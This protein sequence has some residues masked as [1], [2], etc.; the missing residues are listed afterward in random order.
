MLPYKFYTILFHVYTHLALLLSIALNFMFV[1]WSEEIDN[2]FGLWVIG[3]HILK[4]ATHRCM[5]AVF[6]DPN[7]DDR[8]WK[9]SKAGEAYRNWNKKIIAEN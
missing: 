8:Q 5:D 3:N 6:W 1:A 9:Q 7:P 2:T 4:D